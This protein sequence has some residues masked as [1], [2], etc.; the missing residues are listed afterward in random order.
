M[1]LFVYLVANHHEKLYAPSD[2]ASDDSFLQVLDQKIRSSEAFRDLDARTDEIQAQ[3]DAQ[4]LYRYTKLSEAGKQLSLNVYSKEET[5]LSSF[6]ER[7]SL[8]RDEVES[9][10]RILTHEYGWIEASGDKLRITQKGR[11]DM[12]TFADLAYGRM[13]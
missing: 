8:D 10:L 3:I 4:P 5:D 7:R 9:Q 6:F 12:D 1:C 2:F 13:K 11:Q